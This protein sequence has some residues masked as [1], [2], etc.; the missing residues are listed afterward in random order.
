MVS[1]LEG[2][3]VQGG[4]HAFS[5]NG[6]FFRGTAAFGTLL[7]CCDVISDRSPRRST[8]RREPFMGTPWNPREAPNLEHA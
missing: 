5:K 8:E 1:T 3:R 7:H 6:L 2:F 4:V